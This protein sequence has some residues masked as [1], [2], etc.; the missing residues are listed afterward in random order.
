MAET[1][2]F[3]DSEEIINSDGEISYDRVYVADQFAKYFAMFIG[4]GV[5]SNSNMLQVI[6][7]STSNM[8]VVVSKGCAWINGYWYRNDS[9]LNL[10][11]S[12]ADG[13]LSRYDAIT[14]R[15]DTIK[16]KITTIVVEGDSSAKPEKP[17]PVRNADYYDLILAYVYVQ[18]GIVKIQSKDIIDTRL[19]ADLCGQVEALVKQPDV[20]AYGAQLNNFI[21][22]YINTSD[23][24]Y[25]SFVEALNTLKEAYDKLAKEFEASSEEDF[26][27]WFED[28]K[29]KL[30]EAP[31]T[32]LQVQ[33]DELRGHS[34][35]NVPVSGWNQNG[36]MFEN[37]ISVEGILASDVPIYTLYSLNEYTDEELDVF[38]M[39]EN[40]ES[41]NGFVIVRTKVKPTIDFKLL[42][43][44]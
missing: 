18:K 37:K 36:S 3:F 7:N 26:N 23:D 38:Y 41:F 17:T 1:S 42:L 43:K 34:I 40:L 25:N 13:V 31:A 39:L 12:P 6:S 28:I 2:G 14:L 4:N 22:N 30:G 9:E 11:I 5:F 10:A 21:E 44:V 33:I 24:T 16:R 19:D 29:S 27:E 8:S 20:S 32:R 35:I 15:F